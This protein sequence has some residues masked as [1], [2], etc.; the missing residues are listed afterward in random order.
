VITIA[1]RHDEKWATNFLDFTDNF[2][3]ASLPI[4]GRERGGD[5]PRGAYA[6]KFEKWKNSLKKTKWRKQIYYASICLP[7]VR[8]GYTPKKELVSESCRMNL[9]SGC[10]NQRSDHGPKQNLKVLSSEIN[11]YLFEMIQRLATTVLPKMAGKARC[12]KSKTMYYS[13]FAHRSGGLDTSGL[14]IYMERRQLRH[15]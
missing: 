9:L 11:L 2:L 15:K 12:F 10:W 13:V 3:P 5:T 7:P 6:V 1:I 8:I 4:S 14:W